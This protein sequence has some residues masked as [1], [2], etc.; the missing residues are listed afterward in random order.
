[1]RGKPK[2]GDGF[3]R[4]EIDLAQRVDDPFAVGADLRVGDSWKRNKSATVIGR[5]FSV[6]KADIGAEE[7][8]K[9][10]QDVSSEVLSQR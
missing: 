2:R 1:M 9:A 5:A 8:T 10:R 4:F 3:V 7:A 6:A